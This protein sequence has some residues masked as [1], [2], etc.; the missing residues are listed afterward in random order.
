MSLP[1]LKYRQ[2]A[3]ILRDGGAEFLGQDGKNHHVWAYTPIGADK[4]ITAGI[5]AHSDGADVK[6][7]YVNKLR[8]AWKLTP[9]DG[10]TDRDF[11]AG[12]WPRPEA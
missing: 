4:P 10:V 6:P 1:I 3:K 11:L 2:L 5:A 9:K 12:N 7:V 8:K